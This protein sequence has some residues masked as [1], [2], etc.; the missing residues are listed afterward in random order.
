MTN[1]EM[2]FDRDTE[3]LQRRA[4]QLG[5]TDDK[6]TDYRID[7]MTRILIGLPGRTNVSAR[8]SRGSF[9]SAA[10]P[11][12]M[13]QKLYYNTLRNVYKTHVLG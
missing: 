6:R 13:I 9:A 12:S 1:D 2:R 11:I 4:D 3:S 8:N 10:Q 7:R 5:L